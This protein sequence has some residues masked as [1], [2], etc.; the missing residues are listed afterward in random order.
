MSIDEINNLEQVKKRC[1]P[2]IMLSFEDSKLLDKNSLIKYDMELDEGDVVGACGGIE[3]IKV[4]NDIYNGLCFFLKKHKILIA[5]KAFSNFN[6]ESTLNN[7]GNTRLLK[8]LN[9]ILGYDFNI[10]LMNDGKRYVKN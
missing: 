8:S 4:K 5:G 1:N 9:K 2:E 3:V 6:F 7:Q 10:I